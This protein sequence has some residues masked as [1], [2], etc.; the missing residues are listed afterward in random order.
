MANELPNE[1]VLAKKVRLTLDVG[2]HGSSRVPP[3]TRKNAGSLCHQR[4]YSLDYRTPHT[5]IQ[6]HHRNRSLDSVLQQIPEGKGPVLNNHSLQSKDIS[7]EISSSCSSNQLYSLTTPGP[8]DTDRTSLASDDSGIFNSDDGDRNGKVAESSGI[9]VDFSMPLQTKTEMREYQNSVCNSENSTVVMSKKPPP[10]ESWLLRLFESKLF[11]MSIAI[12]YLFNSKESGVQT[13][14]GNRMFSFSDKEVDFYLPQLVS[15]YVHHADLAEAIHPYLVYR[16]RN[17]VEFSLQLAWLLSAFCA[18]SC[19][20]RRR[21]QGAKMKSLILSEELRPRSVTNAFNS[22][23]SSTSPILSPSKKTHHRS[24]SDATGL[25]LESCGLRRCSSS[26]EQPNKI[27]LGEL[28]S[29]HAFDNRCTCFDSCEGVFS[30]LKGIKIECHC[31]APRLAP[32]QEFVK[33]LINIGLRLQAVPTKELKT[34][35]LQAELSM[36]NLNL[37]ARVW[38]PIHSATLS[39]LVVRVPPQAAVVLNSKDKVRFFECLQIYRIIYQ[40]LFNV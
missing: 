16:C 36:L 25:S 3:F 17:S 10:R 21:S 4:N 37:P 22:N 38:L 8:K 14:I 19:I 34:Q 40:A 31:Q 39:H 9:V 30:D 24:L 35:I 29:G 6:T 33:A 5:N 20:P 7:L 26:I 28:S 2:V 12:T 15:L 13:Y 23:L 18:D 32:E 27:A 11:D 1:D